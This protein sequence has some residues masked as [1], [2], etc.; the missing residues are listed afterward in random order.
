[1][2]LG[3]SHQRPARITP[4]R[5]R[6]HDRN[7]SGYSPDVS[8]CGM[9][10]A[11]LPRAV[12][13]AVPTHLPVPCIGLDLHRADGVCQMVWHA[14]GWHAMGWHAMGWH[15]MG[16]HAMGWHAMGWH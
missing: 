5:G 4:F 6:L 7:A 2:S 13:C 12:G 16:W 1:M 14:M 9:Y 15:A 10:L 11:V 3:I 8:A